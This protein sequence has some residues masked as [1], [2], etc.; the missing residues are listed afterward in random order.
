[1][2]L[3]TKLL[4]FL[5][6]IIIIC[7]GTFIIYKQIEISNRQAAIETQIVEQKQLAD[8]IMRSMSQYATKQDID[9]FAKNQN[10]NLDA[11]KKDLAS[12]NA[13]LV[14]LN[15][16]VV[17]SKGQSG[18][19]QG[20]TGTT[21]NTEPPKVDPNH[22]D[23]YGYLSNRQEYSLNEQF[24]NVIVPFGKVGFS[25]WKDK[26]WDYNI[27]PREYQLT[28]VIGTDENQ[29]HYVYNK[30]A[31]KVGDK[32]YDIQVKQAQTLEEYPTAKFSLWNPKL[33]L[34]VSGGVGISTAPVKG[35][36]SI[37]V[38]MG[39]MSYGRFKTTPDL[40]IMQVG[41]GYQVNS[42]RPDITINPINYNIGKLLPGNV[43]NNTYLGPSLQI[44]TA[45]NIF[46][47]AALGLGF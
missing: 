14:A 24:E 22:P 19:G 1:M 10:L 21:P 5:T 45:G 16:V 29:R 9:N 31:V 39:I 23:P 36:A 44:N 40:S 7:A 43:A 2:S 41:V 38:S 46:L 6:G 15:N 47:G 17:V 13:N 25:A 35:D 20:S 42:Q 12:L 11:I 37:G 8:N 30:F 26:P 33:H 34:N 3:T 32:S 4:L 27:Y 28:N 18:S